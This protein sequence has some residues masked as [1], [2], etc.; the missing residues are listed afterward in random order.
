MRSRDGFRVALNLPLPAN[1]A[2]GYYD[3]T[4]K[5]RSGGREE[6]G[7]TRL[8]AAPSEAYA[9]E[10]LQQ[11]RRHWGFNLPLYAVKSR[12]NWGIGDFADLST[13]MRWAGDLGAAFVGV[14][15]LHAFGGLA[16]ADPS[17]Y[18][19]ASRVFLNIL[20]LNLE[21]TPEMADCREAQD[22]LASPEF[23]AAK[24][25]LAAAPLVP[26]REIYQLKRG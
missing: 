1:L 23:Q 26:Y 12:T 22:L 19:P 8:I 21:M 24:S 14:N 15:P 10:W 9:P 6:T 18:S 2:L 17:P 25:R 5:V 4:L 20:Y 13:V 16:G 7:Q 3:L 11:G